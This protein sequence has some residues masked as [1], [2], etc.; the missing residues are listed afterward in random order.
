[1]SEDMFESLVSGV[2][3]KLEMIYNLLCFG[4]IMMI[5]V[6][7]LFIEYGSVSVKTTKSVLNKSTFILVVS[8]VA[9]YCF[10]FGFSHKAYGGLIGTHS[11]FSTNL[12][13]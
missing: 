10:G 8:S 2:A 5:Q 7:F 4:V 6:G 12:T 3:S 13:A 9:F 11:F 1:M